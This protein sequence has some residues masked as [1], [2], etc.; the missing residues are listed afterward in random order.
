MVSSGDGETPDAANVA[1]VC[2]GSR[3]VCAEADHETVS[4]PFPLVLFGFTQDA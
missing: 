1:F 2:L 3:P 4:F